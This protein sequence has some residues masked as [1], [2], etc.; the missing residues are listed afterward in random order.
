MP[1]DA[2]YIPDGYWHVIK[3]TGRNIGL[4][5]EFGAPRQHHNTHWTDAML[6]MERH[7]GTLWSEKRRLTATALEGYARSHPNRT[8][9][10]CAEPLSPMPR[11][12]AEFKGWHAPGQ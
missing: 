2:L 5:F 10:Q 9:S 6:A 12:I 8:I 11:S 3:S 1:G 7:P 4:A